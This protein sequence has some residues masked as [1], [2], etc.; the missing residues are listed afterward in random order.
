MSGGAGIEAEA[1]TLIAVLARQSLDRAPDGVGQAAPPLD[2]LPQS[3]KG[4]K[5][6]EAVERLGQRGH[7][8]CTPVVYARSPFATRRW[9]SR[10]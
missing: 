4:G 8:S 6:S 1:G 7:P 10:F 2:P 3:K 5:E 9:C